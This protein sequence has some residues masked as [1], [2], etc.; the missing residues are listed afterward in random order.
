MTDSAAPV[1]PLAARAPRT[2]LPI[3][4]SLLG[5]LAL[6]NYVDRG[7]LSVAAPL[8]KTELGISNTQ[9][10]VLLAAFF[11]TYTAAMYPS[12]W[13]ADRVNVN[14]VLAGGLVL[15]SL[16]TAATALAHSFFLLI[17]VRMLLGAGESVTFP[18]FGRILARHVSQ[19]HRCVANAVI[20]SGQNLGPAIGTYFC[21]ILMAAYG[22]RP[23]FVAI[24]LLGLIWLLPW[25]RWM[26]DDGGIDDRTDG[27]V[28]AAEILCTRSFWG[29]AFGQFCSNYFYY[30]MLLWLP[31]YL[32]GERHVSMQAMAREA[33]LFYLT[34]VSAALLGGWIADAAIRRGAG[35]NRVR[36]GCMALG[37]AIVAASVLGCAAADARL[38][39]VSLMIMGI[40]CGIAGPNIFVFAQTLAGP[41]AAGKW[42]GLQN[43]FAN[44]AGVVV[45]PLSGLIADYTGHFWWAFVIAS[46]VS[47]LGGIFWVFVVGPLQQIP[48]PQLRVVRAVNPKAA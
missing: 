30:F 44:L 8:L 20:M 6:I 4:L 42:T 19:D 27:P 48:W 41:S 47:V 1:T 34:Y 2:T 33:A 17:L 7:N 3:F 21:G 14:W 46:V 28:A 24:G 38:S 15:W 45:G 13:L 5:I 43:G 29:T 39:F 22:W 25:V 12:G 18:S 37:H 35:T 10:G 11:W 32:V 9:L 40:G 16:A 36:K 23:V 31:F 26:P